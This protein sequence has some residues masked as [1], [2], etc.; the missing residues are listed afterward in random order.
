VRE[1]VRFLSTVRHGKTKHREL[2]RESLA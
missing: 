2:S 1:E